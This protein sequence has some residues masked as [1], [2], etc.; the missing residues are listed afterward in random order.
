[1]Q[2]I[3]YNIKSLIEITTERLRQKNPAM[4]YNEVLQTIHQYDNFCRRTLSK[5]N[6]EKAIYFWNFLSII[7]HNSRDL[8]NLNVF[9][10]NNKELKTSSETTGI[11]ESSQELM[12][13]IIK[14]YQT[15]NVSDLEEI[16]EKKD[17]LIKKGLEILKKTKG[18]ESEALFHIISSIRNLYRS[19]SPL[20][21]LLV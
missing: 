16:D 5:Q 10:D 15:K 14:T 12:Q 9:L 21:G 1:M 18:N 17:K 7:I 11:L 6:K 19:T 13:K 3:L 20:T 8:Y 4:N 2:K